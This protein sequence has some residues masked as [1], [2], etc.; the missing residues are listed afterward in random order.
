MNDVDNCVADTGAGVVEPTNPGL[1]GRSEPQG[2]TGVAAGSVSADGGVGVQYRF[3]MFGAE[4]AGHH[5]HPQIVIRR[6]APDAHSWHPFPIGDCWVF[7]SRPIDNPP[8]FITVTP[9]SK[10]LRGKP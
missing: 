6:Y 8:S 9:L 1:A 7:R 3:D 4:D 5:E 2:S 10:L